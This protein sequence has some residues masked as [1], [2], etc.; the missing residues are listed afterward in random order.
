MIYSNIAAYNDRQVAKYLKILLKDNEFSNLIKKV[1]SLPSI[2]A[3]KDFSSLI[4][5]IKKIK[6]IKDFQKVMLS[7]LNQ[8]IKETTDQIT[9]SGIESIPTD[10]G[11][12]YISNHRST[13]LD[14]S[15]LNYILSSNGKDTA[16]NGAGD[17]IFETKW[18]GHL[19]RLNKGFIVKRNVE[20][21]DK[22]IKEA[23]RLSKY[24][25]KLL[26]KGNSVWIANRPGRAKNGI[27][28]TDSVIISMLSRTIKNKNYGEWLQSFNL[29]PISI[30]YEIIPRDLNMAMEVA[31]ELSKKSFN[32]RKNIVN[33]IGAHKGR[34][35]Y[36][37]GNKI[38]GEKRKEI[39]A[40]ID[41]EIISNYKLWDTNWL[42]YLKL[43]KN[44]DP[45]DKKL[46]LDN[47]D[48]DKANKILDRGKELSPNSEQKLYEM[49]A[50][51]VK[52]A[53]QYSESI[54]SLIEH[55]NKLS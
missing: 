38:F 17:N 10:K 40:A 54:E 30:S 5:K 35:H 37:F 27:D 48:I 41:K 50:N 33:E 20:E 26:K 7:L 32:D 55:N 43:E 34:I 21:I 45:K 29:I 49:Y 2:F 22:K 11:I 18:L 44:I 12:L 23:N 1:K 13:S 46:I 28:K 24:I 4:K 3:E 16:Y 6:T 42:A 14:A 39:V 8:N 25:N 15:Y 9:L 19:I 52:T 51:S 36:S 31:G 47:I 53:L